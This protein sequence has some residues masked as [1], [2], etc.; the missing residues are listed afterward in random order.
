MATHGHG[1]I[2]GLFM[3]SVTAKVLHKIN[4]SSLALS[5]EAGQ[6]DARWNAQNRLRHRTGKRSG[7]HSAYAK[8]MAEEFQATVTLFIVCLKPSLHLIFITY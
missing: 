8:A 4:C 1:A 5:R 3:D 7:T 2:E 6:D